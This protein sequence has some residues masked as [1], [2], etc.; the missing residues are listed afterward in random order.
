MVLTN[1]LYLVH[2]DCF[3]GIQLKLTPWTYVLQNGAELYMKNRI[4]WSLARSTDRTLAKFSIKINYIFSPG[5]S[6]KSGVQLT[7]RAFWKFYIQHER[8][9]SLIT[10]HN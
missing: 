9:L 8:S 6:I 10:A 2:Y 1:L 3:T 7:S 4:I 5:F